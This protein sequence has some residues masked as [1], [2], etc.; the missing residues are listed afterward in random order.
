MN[1]L[2]VDDRYAKTTKYGRRVVHGMFLAALVSQLIGMQLPGKR[3]LLVSETLAFKKPVYIGDTVV[4]KAV[5][6]SK[7]SST[8]LVELSISIARAAEVVAAGNA[9]VRVD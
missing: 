7:S 5:T 8:R 1:P 9:V 6:A 4:V 2:H 3:S